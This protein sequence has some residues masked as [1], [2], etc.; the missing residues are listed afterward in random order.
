VS[1]L[2]ILPN[3]YSRETPHPLA[4]LSPLLILGIPIFDLVSVTIIRMR[5]GQPVWV[6][7]TSHVSHRLVRRGY[8]RSQAVLLLLLA[9]SALG[10]LAVLG[11]VAR[12]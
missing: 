7:D 5:R 8:S 3:F 10:A 11:L 6:G 1:V 4:V 12:D 2:A 9:G